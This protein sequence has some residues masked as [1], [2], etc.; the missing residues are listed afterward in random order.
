MDLE[1]GQYFVVKHKSTYATSGFDNP[2]AI[3]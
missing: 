1:E 3:E 2:D